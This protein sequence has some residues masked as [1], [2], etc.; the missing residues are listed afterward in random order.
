MMSITIR[1]MS[2]ENITWGGGRRASRVRVRREYEL[3]RT[4]KILVSNP[5][6]V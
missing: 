6:T 4:F 1:Q 5:P 2:G 3:V